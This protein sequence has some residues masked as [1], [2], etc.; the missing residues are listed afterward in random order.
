MKLYHYH[1]GLLPGFPMGCGVCRSEKIG[2]SYLLALELEIGNI[3]LS[4]LDTSVGTLKLIEL[5]QTLFCMPILARSHFLA[6]AW[7]HGCHPS[8]FRPY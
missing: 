6:L 8:L 3:E 1:V 2:N 4:K 5:K 7:L